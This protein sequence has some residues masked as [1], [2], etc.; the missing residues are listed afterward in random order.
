MDTISP[1]PLV[2]RLVVVA[3]LWAERHDATLAR[4][5]REVVNDGGFFARLASPGAST[6][7]ATFDKFAR[8]LAEPTNWPGREVP[9]EAKAL[10]HV[11]GVTP[12]EAAA[13]AGIAGDSSPEL[14]R[15]AA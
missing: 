8:H 6:T 7:T 12:G 3:N 5:G 14:G 10:A 11:A 1:I 15:D 9:E 2:D 4:L 13:S